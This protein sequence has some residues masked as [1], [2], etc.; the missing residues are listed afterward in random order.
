M[1]S[2]YAKSVKPRGNIGQPRSN[3]WYLLFSETVNRKRNN[4][5]TGNTG[6]VVSTLPNNVL[7]ILVSHVFESR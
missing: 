5:V 3:R 4:Y 2:A 6:T 1:L 7:L